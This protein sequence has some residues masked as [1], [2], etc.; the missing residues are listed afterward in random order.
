MTVYAIIFLGDK[1]MNKNKGYINDGDFST[2]G[3]F[4]NVAKISMIVLGLLIIFYFISILLSG[5]V[6]LGNKAIDYEQKQTAVIQYNE[7]LAGSTFKMHDSDY[8]VLFYEAK[9]NDAIVYSTIITSYKKL[10]DKIP[11]YIVNLKNGFNTSYISTT[12]NK[13]AQTGDALKINGPTLIRIK[14]GSNI[15][16]KE[17]ESDIK[18]ILE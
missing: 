18:A 2:F 12:S 10:T 13:E 5:N 9:G 1:M 7:I 8:Y 17:G 4:G 11:L 3:Q 6:A 15:L 14:N 16:Y